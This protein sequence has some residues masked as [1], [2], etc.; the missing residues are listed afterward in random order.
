MI[1]HALECARAGLRVHPLYMVDEQLVCSCWRGAEC[2]EKQ[3]GKHPRLAKWQAAATN[4]VSQVGAW[5]EEWPTAGIGIATGR[6]SRVWVLDCD[7]DEALAWY[8]AKCKEHGL[9]KTIGARTGRGRHFWWRF[10]EDVNIR[11]AQ[12][13]APGVDVRG[14]GGY[15]IAPPTRHRSGARYEWLVGGAYSDV[16]EM[17][18][19]WLVELVREKVKPP[20]APRPVLPT[21]ATRREIEAV[22]RVAVD[23]DPDVRRRIGEQA[24]GRF[25]AASRP[26]VDR[27]P[28]PSC[29]RDEVWLYLDG[30]PAVCHHRKSCNWAGPLKRLLEHR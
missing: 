10:P 2:P 18:P 4:D 25:V 17:A 23:T 16:P 22:F 29:G 9:V 20:P 8:R 5:W 26:Y 14:D 13:I 24:G 28:C 19:S 1:E 3:R 21:G 15:V 12:G 7:G 6:A 11:N 27:I 30:G